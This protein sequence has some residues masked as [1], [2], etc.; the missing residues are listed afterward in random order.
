MITPAHATSSRTLQLPQALDATVA[1]TLADTL[2][3]C[4]GEDVVIDAYHVRRASAQGVQVLRWAA[5]IWQSDRRSL[6][7]V[8]DSFDFAEGPR[9]P[10]RELALG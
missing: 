6:I 5:E 4:R 2:R 9:E 10:G 1:A 8:N 3:D 7:V